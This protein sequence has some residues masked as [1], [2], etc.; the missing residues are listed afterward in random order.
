ML[1]EAFSRVQRP[2]EAYKVCPFD[3]MCLEEEAKET[4]TN[5]DLPGALSFLADEEQGASVENVF[6]IG[7]GQVLCCFLR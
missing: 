3:A 1:K 7:G 6:V 4:P 5:S 2:W